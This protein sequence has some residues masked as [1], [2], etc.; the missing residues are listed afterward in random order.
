VL[1]KDVREYHGFAA[2]G[3]K[4]KPSRVKIYQLE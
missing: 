3:I 1:L 2:V 4:I